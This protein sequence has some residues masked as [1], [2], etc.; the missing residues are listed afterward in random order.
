LD[1]IVPALSYLTASNR[2]GLGDTV[3]EFESGALDARGRGVGVVGG[4][5]PARVCVPPAVRQGAVSVPCVYRRAR[6]NM[7]GSQR[8]VAHAE[9]EGVQFVWQ[10]QPEAFLGNADNRVTAVRCQRIHL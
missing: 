9:E 5:A 6:A 1:N 4:G 10:A 8:E 2:K 3:A 7:P